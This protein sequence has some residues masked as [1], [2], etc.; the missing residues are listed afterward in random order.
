MCT[1]SREVLCNE[2][3]PTNRC[4]H[5]MHYCLPLWL[6]YKSHVQVQQMP[7]LVAQAHA[8]KQDA[9]DIKEQLDAAAQQLQMKVQDI[10]SLRVSS[11]CPART[12]LLSC[13]CSEQGLYVRMV[14]VWPA[15]KH[16]FLSVCAT[17]AIVTFI[18]LQV[19]TV[20]CNTGQGG[21]LAETAGS[22]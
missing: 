12:S 18:K 1:S 9:Q 11:P 19:Y 22:G 16:A 2:Q 21:G 10:T 4:I 20:P 7:A 17:L 15:S 6:K 3:N 8:A 13:A 5:C 14:H